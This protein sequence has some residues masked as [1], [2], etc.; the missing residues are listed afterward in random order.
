MGRIVVT[1]FVSLD[2][3]MADPGG[4][5][6]TKHG[7]WTFQYDR[8]DEGNAFKVDE[9]TAADALLLGR[10]TYEGFAAAWPTYGTED[11]FSAKMNSI[12][13]YVVS[14]T[15][16]DEAASWTNTQVVRGDTFAELRRL[17]AEPGGDLLVA[18]SGRLVAGLAENDLVDEYRLMV[19]PI[20]LGTG[21]RLFGKVSAPPM[22]V[23]DNVETVGEGIVILTYRAVG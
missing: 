7:G 14:N 11:P 19:F 15:L 8:G 5:E 23:L 18:G 6:G 9:L 10:K 3:V 16:T 4:A 1:E 17:R 22:L 12:R 13:K 20:V 2:G 21:K